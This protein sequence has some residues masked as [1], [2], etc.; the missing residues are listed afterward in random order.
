ME[1]RE[2]GKDTKEFLERRIARLEHQAEAH[3]SLGEYPRSIELLE[4]ACRLSRIWFGDRLSSAVPRLQLL[5]EQ[6]RRIGEGAQAELRSRRLAALE[7][8]TEDLE[9]MRYAR[10]LNSL[11]VLRCESG[12]HE[13]ALQPLAQALEIARRHHGEDGSAVAVL[14]ANLAGA[15]HVLG[16]HR[17]AEALY[18]EA[19]SILE[20]GPRRDA[21]E[22]LYCLC[23]LAELCI[24]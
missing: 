24:L 7:S 18:L 4:E 14:A 17:Q 10:T 1:D 2:P 15:C 16:K 5:A 6:Y 13:G 8:S 20:C 21:P 9:A 11:G 23:S 12:Q 3:A 22:V 19:L